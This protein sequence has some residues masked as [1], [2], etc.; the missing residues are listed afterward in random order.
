MLA[1]NHALFGGIIAVTV[2]QPALFVPAAAASHFVLDVLPHFGNAESFGRYSKRYYRVIKID[3]ILTIATG[4]S[5]LFLWPKMGGI[6]FLGG[7][8]AVVPDLLWPLAPKTKPNSLLGKFFRFHKAIQLSE[9]RKGIFFEMV[10]LG[11]FISAMISIFL[12]TSH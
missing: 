8:S 10:W 3:G 7:F 1:L 2:R 11:V 4:I 6:I 9:S 5:L 12:G